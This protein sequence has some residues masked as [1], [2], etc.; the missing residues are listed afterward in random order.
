MVEAL[1]AIAS[2]CVLSFALSFLWGESKEKA[3]RL[4]AERESAQEKADRISRG[5]E[6]L[7][8][9]RPSR[10]LLIKHWERRL[11]KATEGDTDTKLPISEPR[12]D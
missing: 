8:G 5:V 1:F 3:G 7:M 6:K 12:G 9:P 4:K 2:V 11:R 10:R